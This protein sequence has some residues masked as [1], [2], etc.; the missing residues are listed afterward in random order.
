MNKP[1]KDDGSNQGTQSAC[2]AVI[3]AGGLNSRMGGRNKAFLELEGVTIIERIF[4]TLTP[5][6]REILLVTREPGQY[7]HLPCR[8]VTDRIDA[9]S[10]LTGIHAGLT[11]TRND[12]VFTVACD[13][14]FLQTALV[15][16]LLTQIDAATDI[17]V[18]AYDNHYEPL[19]AIYSRRCIPPI[20]RQLMAGDLTIYHLYDRMHL[21]T[22]PAH[23][24]RQADAAMVSFFNVNTPEAYA[25]AQ[26]YL[27]G[28][29]PLEN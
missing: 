7:G 4:A 29:G 11:N 3:L 1:I 16:L 22:I 14:P 23:Q 2:S 15:E 27:K 21:K 13:V 19:C 6:F 17:V 26:V 18:P 8:I 9:R 28:E 25:A 20:E 24:I 12:F 10:S 5:L